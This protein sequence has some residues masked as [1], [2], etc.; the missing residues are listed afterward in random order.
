M[1]S[2]WCGTCSVITFATV[3]LYLHVDDAKDK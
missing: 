1:T 3:D 2:L